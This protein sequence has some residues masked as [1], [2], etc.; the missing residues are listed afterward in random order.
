[1]KCMSVCSD[2][3]RNNKCTSSKTGNHYCTEGCVPGYQG[4]GCGKPCYSP[5]GNCT[6]CPGGCD[7]GYCQMASAC[8]SGCV[9]S[10]YGSDCKKCSSGC[11][12]CN[13]KTGTCDDK[14]AT[15]C[16]D[17]QHCSDCDSTTGHCITDCEPGYYDK[18]CMSVC[19]DNCRNNKCISSKIGSG[20]CTEGCIPGYQG[21]N[22][23]IPCD[24]PGGNCTPCPGGCDG[25]Y[26]QLGSSCV[27]GC[28]DSYYG[29]GCESGRWLT[30]NKVNTNTIPKSILE[31][32]HQ[33]DEDIYLPN[34]PA[35]E[36]G[37]PDAFRHSNAMYSEV[38]ER[39]TGTVVVFLE[40]RYRKTDLLKGWIHL[41][42]T[43]LLKVLIPLGKTDL[44][45]GW[46]HL[47]KSD[48]LKGW[49]P[50]GKTD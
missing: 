24:S 33:E 48:L 29:T 47:G 23:N 8:Y 37:A 45:K 30:Y 22:C 32:T 4:P 46:I 28:V 13:R 16:H 10:F 19:S 41:W 38:N 18:K 15:Q 36:R 17:N 49:I 14:P 40:E 44:L 2:N 21:I 1:M 42:K 35:E 31:E 20:N 11:T 25:G 27:S 6:A 7:A 3:C 43:D 34:A 39:E 50:L 26:C 5:G 9:D 12:T